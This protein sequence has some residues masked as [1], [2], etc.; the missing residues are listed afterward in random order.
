MAPY[1]AHQFLEGLRFTYNRTDLPVADVV[2]QMGG[3][4][5]LDSAAMELKPL[6]PDEM[7]PEARILF[8][9]NVFCAMT[10]QRANRKPMTVAEAKQRMASETGSYAEDV[11]R[12]IVAIPDEELQ[13]IMES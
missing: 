3:H 6:A 12:A 5:V 7:L 4:A 1:Y 10:G 8:A 13:A 11:V 9:A 2:Y